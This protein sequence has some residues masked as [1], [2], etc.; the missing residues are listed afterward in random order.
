MSTVEKYFA[1]FLH[2]KELKFTPARRAILTEIFTTHDHFTVETLH[3]RL[4]AR[5]E[6]LSLAT[7]YRMIPLL[8]ESHMI[9]TAVQRDGAVTYEHVF[10]H[11]HHDH[12]VCMKCGRVIE[13]EDEIIRRRL[14]DICRGNNFDPIDHRVS[15]RGRCENCR[16]EREQ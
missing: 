4:K 5:G 11:K 12:L 13:F 16:E 1:D 7:V 8:L 2:G 3:D 15:V 9:Q 14:L 10:G 6:K